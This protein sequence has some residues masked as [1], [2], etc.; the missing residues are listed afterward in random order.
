MAITDVNLSGYV[1]ADDG[2]AV[3][4]ITISLLHA[5]TDA[6]DID[7]G[8]ET[9]TTTSST[10]YWTFTEAD[11]DAT[12]DIKITSE[13]GGQ[14][15]YIPWADEITLKTV[16]TSALKVRGVEGAA[17]PIYLF[18]D[19]AD[20]DIDVWRINAADGGAL[21]FDSRAS[22]SS[23]SDL[24][25]QM[26]ITPHATVAS[27]SVTIPGILD[28]NGSVDWDVTDVQVDSSGDIDL[29]STANAAA[30]IYLQENGGTSGTIKIHADQGTSESSIQ[31]LSDAGG[32]DI[33]AA[34]GKDVDIAGGTV[35]ITSS[36]NAASA[37]Y[38]RANAGTSETI[39]V[40]A[41]QGTGTGSIELL[42]DAG[43]IELDA[44]TDIILDAGDADI[45]LKDDGTLF[46]T[47]TNSSGELVIKS[48]SSGTTAITMS[49]ANVTIA[50]DLTISG[51]DLTMGTNTD[52]FILVAD[53]TNY[54]PVIVSGDVTIANDGAVTIASTAVESGMLNN[55]VISGQT[56]LASGGIA[57]ADEIAISDGGTLKKIGVDNFII[58]SPALV[59]EAAIANGDYLLFLD[60]GATGSAKKE[61]LADLVGLMAG[62]V[63]ST[64]LSDSSS[65]LSLDIQNMTASTTIADADLIV[66]D[67]GA[68][69]TLRKMTRANFIE[70]AALDAINIDGGAIDG[71]V[72]GAN[73][74]AAGTFAAIVGTTIDASTDFTIGDTVITDGTITDSSGLTI[75]AAVDLG[76][77]TL[78]STGSMQIRTIDYSDGD[79]AITIADGGGIT[80]GAGLTVTGDVVLTGESTISTSSDDLH[81]MPAANIVAVGNAGGRLILTAESGANPADAV[82]I[83]WAESEGTQAMEFYYNGSANTLIMKS[84]NVDPIWTIDRAAGWFLAH[85]G[86]KI[87]ATSNNNWLDDSTHGSGSTTM[88]IGNET[89]TTSSDSRV[90]EDI[91]DTSVDAVELLDKMRIVDFTW[92]DPGDTVYYGKNYRGKYVG[93][94]AQ[95]TI[96]HA[97]WIINDQGGGKDCPQCSIGN[98]CDEHLP[99]H[100]EYHHLVPTLVKAIQE[101]NKEISILK[102]GN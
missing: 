15:R 85:T 1:R 51:D 39:V 38:L 88:Y 67:D 59:S 49:G 8:A 29:V 69:G 41:D 61:A 98:E 95:E 48:S 78:T 6:G 19:Q 72:I 27:S 100:V 21:T 37:I 34:T 26:T 2:D 17:A 7:G 77:N 86:M 75:A 91:A 30:A 74:A 12:Y 79:V 87:G 22:G 99:W 20:Q 55:N 14:L 93:M 44:G 36:D 76:S 52:T 24:V 43:G 42:S 10:G 63:T 65:V 80:T 46:G 9:T 31:L 71:T 56:E 11:I 68:G 64:G 92:N 102:G 60:G 23:D 28:I 3:S 25:A 83:S 16:D 40:H 45:F 5:T 13:G 47:L 18:A 50:G 4:G 62:T 97:P 81:L 89:I 73:T 54:N 66:I 82:G 101:L 70:S 84:Q 53:G 35:N 94:V 33:N 58:D 32:V 57:A 96:K 90:K